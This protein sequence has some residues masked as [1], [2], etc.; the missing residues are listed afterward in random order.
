M[1]TIR[2]FIYHCVFDGASSNNSR[3]SFI[4]SLTYTGLQ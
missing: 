2:V 1:K 3:D 4:N